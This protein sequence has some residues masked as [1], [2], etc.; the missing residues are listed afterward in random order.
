MNAMYVCMS[1]LADCL[2]AA[3]R[4]GSVDAVTSDLVADGNI[5]Y[6]RNAAPVH[7]AAVGERE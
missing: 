5:D 7:V 6:V 3:N 2:F 1:V 4:S